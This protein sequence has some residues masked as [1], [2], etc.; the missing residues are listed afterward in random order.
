MTQR[1]NVTSSAPISI[2][3]A[4]EEEPRKKP[5]DF[6]TFIKPNEGTR[7]IYQYSPSVFTSERASFIPSIT[8]CSAARSTLPTFAVTE[9]T[10]ARTQKRG[11]QFASLLD[12]SRRRRKRSSPVASSKSL[13]LR[14]CGECGARTHTLSHK[15]KPQKAQY[16]TIAWALERVGKETNACERRRRI[17]S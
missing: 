6:R 9:R 5:F 15:P 17:S 11:G 12:Q 8:L 2:A 13:F 1:E 14:C 4:Q 3:V 10:S 7:T 16:F